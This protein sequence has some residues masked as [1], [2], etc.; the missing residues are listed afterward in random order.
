MW[1]DEGPPSDA[2]D[3]DFAVESTGKVRPFDTAGSIP[4]WGILRCLRIIRRARRALVVFRQTTRLRLAAKRSSCHFNAQ[5]RLA[6]PTA[7]VDHR[8]RPGTDVPRSYGH[9]PGRRAR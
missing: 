8:L 5:Y 2:G 1:I 6:P 3:T 9:R 4:S 7:V